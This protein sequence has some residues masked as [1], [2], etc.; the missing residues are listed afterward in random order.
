MHSGTPHLQPRLIRFPSSGLSLVELMVAITI[1]LLVLLAMTALLSQQNR[2]RDEL[3]KSAAQNENGRYALMLLQSDLQHAGFYGQFDGSGALPAALPN[4]CST[5]PANIEEAMGMPVQGYD[6]VAHPIPAP[7]SGCLA[8]ANHVAGT[9]VLVVR[10]LHTGAP[11]ITTVGLVAKRVYAQT[12]PFERV[13][14]R[15]EN[16]GSFTL[17]QKDLVTLAGIRPVVTNIYFISPCDVFAALQTTCTAAADGGS[18]IPTLKRLELGVTAGGGATAFNIVPLVQG[19]EDL[20]V[21]FGVDTDGNGAPSSPFIVAP[22]LAQWPAV[23]AVTINLRARN[24]EPTRGYTDTKIYNMGVA[25]DVNLA[26]DQ[27]KRH[28]YT[29]TVRL[30]NPSGRRE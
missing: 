16:T 2:A 23:M 30:N 7:L 19:I 12:T 13:V 28:V 8:D 24:T 22:T 11:L 18:P 17:L 5:V 4:P 9:D 27:F 1:G 20:Q 25:G 6:A 21:D 15:G 29:T 3:G 26:D 14:D 10:R